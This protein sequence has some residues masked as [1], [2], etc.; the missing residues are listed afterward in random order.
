MT[1]IDGSRQWALEGRPVYTFA[2]DANS[3]ATGDGMG[4]VW[5]L[6]PAVPAK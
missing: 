4:G 6:L 3:N 5:H 2:R 1:R